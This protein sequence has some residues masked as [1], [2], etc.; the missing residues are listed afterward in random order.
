MKSSEPPTSS[1]VA[2]ARM[3]NCTRGHIGICA[4]VLMIMMS[5]VVWKQTDLIA[6]RLPSF[7]QQTPNT[8]YSNRTTSPNGTLDR[9]WSA[10]GECMKDLSHWEKPA[11]ISKIMGLVFYGRRQSVSILDCY[12][13]RNLVKNGG[14]LDGVIFVE[15][16]R[17]PHDLALLNKLLESEDTYEKWEVEM[18]DIDNFASGFGSSYDRVEDSVM[19]VKIDDDIVFMEDSVIPSIVK[20]KVD[21]PEYFIVS[22]NVVNQPLLSWIHWNLGSIRPY[23]PEVDETNKPRYSK[24]DNQKKFDWKP[25][26]LPSWKGPESFSL[27]SWES[28]GVKHRWL[29][30][31]KNRK[32]HI[33]DTTPIEGTEYHPMGRGWTEWKIGAQEHFSF[34]EN[35]EKKKLSAYKF[36]T[37]DFQYE[38]MGIQFVALLGKDINQAKPIEADDENH[39]SCNMPRTL[40]RHAVAD[41]RG[42]VAHYSFG[43][44]R[45]GMDHTDVLDRY[46]SFALD[47]ICAGPMLWTPNED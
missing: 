23:L 32:D 40:G 38:R 18:N 35:L 44:Q 8:S 46:R 30:L 36:D 41:G 5:T 21:H 14:L 39:F 6:V 45:E 42:V 34:F 4:V 31:N 25:S 29:P 16:T 20:K 37:W 2:S 26:K 17:D 9:F 15:R 27:A 1:L 22:A 13:K 11:D 12:L 33:L 19:Y 3:L 24:I 43:I 7:E 10:N 47:N 28:D